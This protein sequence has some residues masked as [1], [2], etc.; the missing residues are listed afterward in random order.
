MQRPPK[1]GQCGHAGS[2]SIPQRSQSEKRRILHS[3]SELLDA[4]D[5]RVVAIGHT[6]GDSQITGGSWGYPMPY[7]TSFKHDQRV[8]GHVDGL[9]CAVWK[10]PLAAG[11]AM[12]PRWPSD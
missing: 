1:N 6:Q 7:A 2:S 12:G 9:R 5:V 4:A 10:L 11:C 3:P 8:L